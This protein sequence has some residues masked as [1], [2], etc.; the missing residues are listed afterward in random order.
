MNVTFTWCSC[1]WDQF[2][3]IILKLYIQDFTDPGLL[4]IRLIA[5]GWTDNGIFENVDVMHQTTRIA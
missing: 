3:V 1:N 4:K 5:F 2:T